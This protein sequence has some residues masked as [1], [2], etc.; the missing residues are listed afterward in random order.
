MTGAL[1]YAVTEWEEIKLL[2]PEGT[3]TFPVDSLAGSKLMA[4]GEG[5]P[6]ILELDEAN[7]VIDIHRTR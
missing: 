5:T 3:E 6:V 4:F 2:T 7:T 1:S